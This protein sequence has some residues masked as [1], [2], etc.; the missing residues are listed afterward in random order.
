MHPSKSFPA[1]ESLPRYRVAEALRPLL[2]DYIKEGGFQVGD[3]FLSDRDVMKMSCRSRTAVR[4]TFDL[5]QEEGWV[6]RRGGR[7][8]FVG[9]RLAM[10]NG[11]TNEGK[12]RQ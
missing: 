10:I 11:Q 9:P 7:G 12:T 4:R 3:Q 8:T 1:F 2:I 5:L 6:E